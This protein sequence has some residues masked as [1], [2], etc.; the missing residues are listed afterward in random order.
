MCLLLCHVTGRDGS[1]KPFGGATRAS[2]HCGRRRMALSKALKRLRSGSARAPLEPSCRF[3]EYADT[4]KCARIHAHMHARTRARAKRG[5]HTHTH[6]R[7]CSRARALAHTYAPTHTRSRTR[8]A[9]GP[10]DI[11][12]ARAGVWGQYREPDQARSCKARARPLQP[13]FSAVRISCLRFSST[14]DLCTVAIG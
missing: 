11:C 2:M 12:M 13:V 10:D 4:R 3:G 5:T 8:P 7:A 6:T 1:T 14:I 9:A